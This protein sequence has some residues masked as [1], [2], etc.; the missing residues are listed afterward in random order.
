MSGTVRR[1]ERLRDLSMRFSYLK[2]TE[3]AYKMFFGALGS[4]SSMERL[5]LV[6]DHTEVNDVSLVALNKSMGGMK[7]L[8]RLMLNLSCS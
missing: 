8:R 5:K 1:M 6:L 4:L 7:N 2:F 3:V